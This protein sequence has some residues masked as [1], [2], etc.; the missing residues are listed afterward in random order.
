MRGASALRELITG[1]TGQT[2]LWFAEL[3]ISKGHEVYGLVRGQIIPRRELF[4]RIIPEVHILAGNLT[5]VS[6]L[7]RVL[8]IARP[9]EVYNLVSC[10]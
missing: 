1:I 6:S 5:D 10:V 8:G 9:D 3:L 2:G 7:F 4:H